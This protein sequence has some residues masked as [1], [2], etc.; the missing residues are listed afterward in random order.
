MPEALI[1]LFD[2]K[3]TE[4]LPWRLRAGS[5]G[6]LDAD[7]QRSRPEG[8]VPLQPPQP[9]QPR[10]PTARPGLPL[11]RLGAGTGASDP[12]KPPNTAMPVA[13]AAL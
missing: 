13:G 4:E 9:P 8:T 12:R 6:W 7:T 3:R 5:R 1:H 10:H 11:P 2:I